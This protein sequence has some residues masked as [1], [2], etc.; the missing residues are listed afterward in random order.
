MNRTQLDST[1]ASRTG[2]SLSVIRRMGFQFQVQPREE[3]ES[4][5]LC[6]IVFCP[7]CRQRTDYPGRAEDGSAVLAECDGCDVFF[8]F[9]DH[10]VFPASPRTAS[11]TS[12]PQRR[13]LPV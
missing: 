2:E 4:D 10:D 9:E 6:L 1:I 8:E 7:F 11:T 3:P 5:E 12:S 13:Y